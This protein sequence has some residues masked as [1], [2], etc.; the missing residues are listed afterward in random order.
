MKRM[1]ALAVAAAALTGTAGVASANH[2]CVTSGDRDVICA[3]HPA[4][5]RPQYCVTSAGRPV[6]CV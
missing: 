2:L 5:S 1:F 4:I 6:V 3:P